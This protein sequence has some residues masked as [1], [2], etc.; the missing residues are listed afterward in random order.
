MP[1]EIEAKFLDIN[2]SQYRDTL[3]S[4]GCTLVHERFQN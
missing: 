1:K 3:I 2:E 4:N